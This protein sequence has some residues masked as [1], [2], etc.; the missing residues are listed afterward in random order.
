MTQTTETDYQRATRILTDEIRREGHPVTGWFAG[1]QVLLLTTTGAKTGEQR[2][3][4]LAY[5]K[6][7]DRYVVTASK[8]G[9]PT[10]P[11]WFHN[12]RKDSTAVIEV[13]RKTFHARAAVPQG[14][15]RQRLWDQHVATH[16]GIGEYPKKTT[17]I[18]P[19]VT[20]ERA[21]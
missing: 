8:G 15:E 5:T 19:I 20:F 1:Q 12:L 17:R 18:I 11:A 3:I 16:T 7:G 2:T 6:D 13:D 9:A 14:E 10:H 4:P 21:A